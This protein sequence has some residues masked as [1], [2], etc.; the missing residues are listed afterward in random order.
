ME[1][2]VD[3]TEQVLS[4]ELIASG[5]VLVVDVVRERGAVVAGQRMVPGAP[6]VVELPLSEG[7][8]DRWRTV[9]AV[10]PT[11]GT[12]A[13][14]SA[15]VDCRS[16]PTLT[17][18][19]TLVCPTSRLTVELS[20]LG[21]QSGRWTV[22][23]TRGDGVDVE[24]RPGES[25]RVRFDLGPA[26]EDTDVAVVVLADGRMID[27]RE[28]TVDCRRAPRV[29]L[30]GVAIS[31][32]GGR[33]EVN[34]RN[35]GDG[36]DEIG[37]VVDGR[38]AVSLPLGPGESETVG[39]EIGGLGEG[40]HQLL[41][42]AGD[43]TTVGVERFEVDC[44]IPTASVD[45]DCSGAVVVLTNQGE[46][47]A[48]FV[49]DLLPADGVAILSRHVRVAREEVLTIGREIG[50]GWRVVITEASE[51]G[52]IASADL[53][54]RCEGG[55]GLR[56]DGSCEAGVATVRLVLAPSGSVGLVGV[57]DSGRSVAIGQAS[58]T[59]AGRVWKVVVDEGSGLAVHA[60]DIVEPL[61]VLDSCTAESST[62]P[63]MPD[64]VL[65]G[66]A[67]LVAVGGVGWIVWTTR[68]GSHSK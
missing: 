11:G 2:T 51:S 36:G 39:V 26:D 12:L 68:N 30:R 35:S 50:S 64:N 21:D 66:L 62:V 56:L 45:S 58:P 25:T 14:D 40:S 42:F 20:N 46:S 32:A 31:C 61:L 19:P 27:R 48:G 38:A 7:D 17:A 49:V 23:R 60:G 44:V 13:S 52:V 16:G 65:V 5:R 55:D 67:L 59:D 4:V 43:G 63:G 15:K 10:Q 33:V 29:E 22:L 37:L 18:V 41:A 9:S 53:D 24:L 34:L 6:V 3:C 47:P 28:V 54:P 1:L 57:L 8:E